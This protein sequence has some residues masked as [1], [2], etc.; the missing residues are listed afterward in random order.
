MTLEPRVTK[1]ARLEWIEACRGIAAIMVLAYHII[2]HFDANYGLPLAAQAIH[3][4]HAGVD[5]FFVIS[6]FVILMVHYPDIGKR[7][8]LGRYLQRRATRLLPVYWVALGVQLVLTYIAGHSESTA[9]II[10]NLL[11]LPTTS[12]PIVEVSWTLQFEL[13]F[14]IVFAVLIIS[15]M[16]GAIVAALWF[17]GALV[18]ALFQWTPPLPGAFYHSFILEFLVGMAVAW[19]FRRTEIFA[20]RTIATIGVLTFAATAI[21][22]DMNWIYG[23]GQLARLCYGLSSGA[24][25]LGGAGA[26][27]S[28]VVQLPALL[29]TLGSASYSL[30]LFHFIFVG[31]FWKTLIATG[32]NM[33]LSPLIS[34]PICIV[35]TIVGGV[36]VSRLVEYPLIN[37]ARAALRRNGFAGPA[38]ASTR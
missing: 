29:Q 28:A 18:A 34:C 30:Y 35:F 16:A 19:Y 25:I 11:P 23:Y 31:L 37:M 36:L 17:A 6:G 9:H 10:I 8:M 14:Y 22:D 26:S 1:P 38:V 5:L 27:R 21:A 13:L 3:F 32:W 7:P 12:G 15:R 20:Y 33:K 2:R 24:I 4:G